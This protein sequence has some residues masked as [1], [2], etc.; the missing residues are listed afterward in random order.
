MYDNTQHETSA[1][2]YYRADDDLQRVVGG[3]NDTT[4][5]DRVRSS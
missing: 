4:G 1:R 3:S 2:M 5:K